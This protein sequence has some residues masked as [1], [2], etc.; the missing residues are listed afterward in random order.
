MTVRRHFI[1][2]A[3][4]AVWGAPFAALAQHAPTMPRIALLST[5]T[6][7]TNLKTAKALGLTIPNSL[8]LFADE[9]IE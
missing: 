2:G 3:S 8:R 1:A 6:R 9:V 5:N 7:V 4:L